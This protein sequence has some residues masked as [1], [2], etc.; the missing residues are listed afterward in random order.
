MVVFMVSSK[1]WGAEA[2]ICSI[3]GQAGRLGD[4]TISDLVYLGIWSHVWAGV[5]ST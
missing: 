1:K 3:V 5:R 2:G 4:D